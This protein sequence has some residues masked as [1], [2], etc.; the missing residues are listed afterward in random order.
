MQYCTNCGAILPPEGIC[1]KCG[2]AVTNTCPV[3]PANTEMPLQNSNTVVIQNTVTPVEKP[4]AASAWFAP[5][6][7][8]LATL[9]YIISTVAPNGIL[10]LLAQEISIGYTD[11]FASNALSCLFSLLFIVLELG[12]GFGLYKA[13]MQRGTSCIQKLTLPVFALPCVIRNGVNILGIT[14]SSGIVWLVNNFITSVSVAWISISRFIAIAIAAIISA[15]VSYMLVR[16]YLIQVEKNLPGTQSE[17][18]S[19]PTA[20]S[21]ATDR[22]QTVVTTVSGQQATVVGGTPNVTV[23]NTQP[24]Y[25]TKSK[26]TA[27][28]L[29]F[30]FGTLGV[31]RFYVG[32]V[33][34]GILWFLTLGFGGIGWFIDLLI[35]ICGSF[36]DA[37]GQYLH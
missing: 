32:K 15:V 16:T 35:I 11:Y 4:L 18:K 10:T 21:V 12:I 37:N 6:T 14:V 19:S 34:T 8:I 2:Q 7:V 25:S 26:T 22:Q 36:Q 28:L 20:A 31:H 1:R 3:P 17:K 24:A 23:I 27:G 33:G 13:A 5:V 9:L 30:F 29:C